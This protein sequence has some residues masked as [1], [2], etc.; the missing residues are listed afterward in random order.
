[1]ATQ[2]DRIETK[3]DQLLARKKPKKSLLQDMPPPK[4]VSPETWDNFLA[5][6]K[7]KGQKVTER[8]YKMMFKKLMAWG[9]EG[10]DLDEVL[11]TSIQNGYTGIFKP[12]ETNR[13]TGFQKPDVQSS[14]H[15]QVDFQAQKEAEASL[16]TST[17]PYADLT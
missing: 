7:D 11:T 16:D 3:L 6:R 1:M 9:T 8:A 13:T 4:G 12:A 10:I 14:T 2:L 15:D 17:N 5:H